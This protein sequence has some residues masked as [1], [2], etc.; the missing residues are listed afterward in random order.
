MVETVAVGS[1]S[2]LALP[3]LVLIHPIA[4]NR[5][6]RKFAFWAFCELPLYGVL[7]STHGLG[8]LPM[9]APDADLLP[10]GIIQPSS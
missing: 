3:H 4:W 2:T 6:S 1:V 8:L 5:Y 10:T 7:G 9:S